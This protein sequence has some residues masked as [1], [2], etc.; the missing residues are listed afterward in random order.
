MLPT[1]HASPTLLGETQTGRFRT[2][3]LERHT[4]SFAWSGDTAGQGF[5]I[6]EARVA[7]NL[8]RYGNTSAASIPIALAEAIAARRIGSGDVVVLNAVGGGIT[9]GAV[10]ARW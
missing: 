10:V 1:H 2:A 7:I 9:A 6:D 4:V 8:D 3:P 5:G